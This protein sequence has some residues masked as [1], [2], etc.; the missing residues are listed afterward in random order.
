MTYQEYL[1]NKKLDFM[2]CRNRLDFMWKNLTSL[3]S[4]FNSIGTST[5]IQILH[6]YQFDC[7]SYVHQALEYCN[8]EYQPIH[9]IVKIVFRESR[10]LI[11]EIDKRLQELT[12]TSES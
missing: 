7:H 9:W 4:S 8:S 6:I 10:K 1:E 5:K 12:T 11:A 3:D 2:S